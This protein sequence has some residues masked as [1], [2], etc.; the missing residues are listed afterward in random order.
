MNLFPVLS[1]KNFSYVRR[2][3]GMNNAAYEIL[4]KGKPATAERAKP[5]VKQTPAKTAVAT[6]GAATTPTNKGEFT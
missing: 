2:P 4:R 3:L 6:S 1:I 5:A